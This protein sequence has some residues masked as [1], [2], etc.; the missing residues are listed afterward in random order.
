M[1]RVNLVDKDSLNGDDFSHSEPNVAYKARAIAFVGVTMG[2]GAI[3]GALAV[4]SIKYII[5][6]K[7]GLAFYFGLTVALQ[8]ILIFLGS[9]TLWFGRNLNDQQ[10]AIHL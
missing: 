9:M 5:P 7:I 8:N 10:G 1:D 2:L 4:L 3:G 6:G